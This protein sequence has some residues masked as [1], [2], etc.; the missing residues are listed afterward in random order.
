MGTFLSSSLPLF[1]FCYK[2]RSCCNVD[3]DDVNKAVQHRRI[4]GVKFPE[5]MYMC[6]HWLL[7]TEFN[8]NFAHHPFETNPNLQLYFISSQMC[9]ELSHQV[10]KFKQRS[11]NVDRSLKLQWRIQDFSGKMVHVMYQPYIEG[12]CQ[13]LCGHT[14]REDG[15]SSGS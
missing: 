12:M 15:N 4:D 3:D 8:G 6:R 7:V 9:L 13:V 14:P 5:K 10:Y 1:F 2:D 11:Q